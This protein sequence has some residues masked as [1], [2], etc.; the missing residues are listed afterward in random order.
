MTNDS[1]YTNDENLYSLLT[2]EESDYLDFK[3]EWYHNAGELI[4]DILCMANSCTDSDKYLIIGIENKTKKIK[5]VSND[6]NRKSEENIHNLIQNSNFNIKPTTFIR[7]LK[8]K[9]GCV[10]VI[11]IKNMRNKPY[12][13]LK[14]KVI[15]KENKERIIRAGVIYTRDGA[16]NTPIN[17]TASEYQIAQMWQERFGLTL[18]PLDRLSIYIQDTEKWQSITIDGDSVYYY[19]DFPEFTIKFHHIQDIG[20]YDWST[21]IGITCKDNLYLK[22]HETILMELYCCHIDDGRYFIVQPEYCWIYYKDDFEDINV[23]KFGDSL[24]DKG[25]SIDYLNTN[26]HQDI[27]YYQIRNSFEYYVEKIYNLP[28]SLE[29]FFQY[30]TLKPILLLETND[31]V[32]DKCRKEFL[33]RNTSK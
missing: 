5:D 2:H 29:H 14:D 28:S 9:E 11:I 15:G 20:T 7:S 33:R 22:Y 16:V 18:N 24:S 27:I 19:S 6:A 31:D 1:Q 32:Y 4:Y 10:D 30:G 3:Q 23:V 13:L 12:F 8:T 26:Y 17:N 25:K 21:S